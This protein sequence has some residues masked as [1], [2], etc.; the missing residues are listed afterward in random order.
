LQRLIFSQNYCEHFNPPGDKPATVSIAFA[1][2]VTVQGNQ[3][4][5]DPQ[6]ASFDFHRFGTVTFMGN[7]GFGIRPPL[8]IVQVLG[9]VP[10]LKS[11]IS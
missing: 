9:Q 1:A 8:T 10:R 6:A 7:I 4:K 11:V 3:T 2:L 5:A